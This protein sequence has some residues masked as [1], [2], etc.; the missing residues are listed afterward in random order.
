MFAQVIS[1][2][3]SQ[4]AQRFGHQAKLIQGAV[5][6]R[7]LVSLCTQLHLT[8]NQFSSVC[9]SIRYSVRDPRVS[10]DIVRQASSVDSCI[11]TVLSVQ[12]SRL[13]PCSLDVALLCRPMRIC[14]D[15]E[16]SQQC[17]SST[18]QWGGGVEI[19][20]AYQKTQHSV[21]E[22][23]SEFWELVLSW[24]NKLSQMI[25]VLLLVCRKTEMSHL[26]EYFAL[27]S[28]KTQSLQFPF[29]DS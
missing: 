28:S 19:R 16:V 26:F 14:K 13:H 7:R 21:L 9:V 20:R 12:E 24:T 1:I 10:Q 5:V 27:E 2:T 29:V 23:C 25:P 22:F 11:E 18:G 6:K 15:R 4:L 17:A 3:G 8:R